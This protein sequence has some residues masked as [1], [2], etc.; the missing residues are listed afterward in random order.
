[1]IKKNAFVHPYIPNSVMDTKKEMLKEIGIEDINALYKEIPED[2]KFKGTLNIPMPFTDEYNLYKHVFNILKQNRTCIENLNFLGGGCWQHYV[3]AICNEIMGRAEFLTAYAG[4]QYSDHGKY[5]IFFEYQSLLA[6]LVGMEVAGLP[7][8]SWGFA[9]GLAIRMAARITGR[10]EVLVPKTISPERLSVIENLSESVDKNEDINITMV[11]YDIDT[12]LLDINDLKSK[13][14]NKTAAVYIENPSYLGFVETQCKVISD[15]VHNYN[16]E[17]I[18][19][20]DPISLGILAAPGEYGADIVVGTLQPLGIPMQCGGGESG[21]IAHSAIEKYI[22]ETPSQMV[23]ICSTI[24]DGE[25]GFVWAGHDFRTSYGVRGMDGKIRKQ[26]KDFVGTTSNL[27]AIGAAVYMTLLGPQGF[28]E[29][30]E[31][32]IL[33]TQYAKKVFSELRGLKI[34][35]GQNNFKEF[36]INFDET[37]KN[38]EE[39]NKEFLKYSIFGG[40]NISTEFPELGN[41]ALYCITEIHSKED[42]DNAMNSLKEILN[43]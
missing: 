21:F 2:L 35:F 37:G 34:I 10:N 39:I 42:I 14:T 26:S 1:M 19:G 38:V 8:Y 36:I 23:S 40:K 32:I 43:K 3:P 18:V 7:L 24:E 41:S 31:A 17:F 33:K 13:M 28:R 11:E 16:A 20:V 6:N 9:A 25:Y 30:G 27:Y 15:V 22:I 29:I 4:N 5:Q 12:G